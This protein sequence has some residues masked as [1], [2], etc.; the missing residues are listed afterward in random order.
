MVS[1]YCLQAAL[2]ESTRSV[3]LI[4]NSEFSTSPFSVLYFLL[5]LLLSYQ[6]ASTAI[7]PQRLFNDFFL[8]SF[9]VHGTG[10]L[11]YSRASMGLAV[12]LAIGL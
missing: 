6:S 10:R 8:S 7:V 11:G 9:C 1:V 2:V 5:Y 12:G 3:Y 4:N